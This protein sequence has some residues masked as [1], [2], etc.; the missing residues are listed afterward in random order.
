[1]SGFLHASFDDTLFGC[2]RRRKPTGCF[3]QCGCGLA[4]ALFP[5]PEFPVF[6][7]VRQQ[8]IET[9]H[10]SEPEQQPSDIERGR[11]VLQ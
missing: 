2:R 6:A 1:M 4:G 7:G 5:A 10:Q 3:R 9:G 8:E 11:Q